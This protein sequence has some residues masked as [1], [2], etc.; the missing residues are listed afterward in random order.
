MLKRR[1]I[2]QAIAAAT[3]GSILPFPSFAAAG[4]LIEAS[5][6]KSDL[7]LLQSIY[8]TL[9]PG[10]YRY[11]TKA[12]IKARFAALSNRFVAPTP[13]SQVY[14]GF[15][16]LLASVRCG[17]SYANFYSQSE[18]VQ[19]ALFAG[20]NRLPFKF[21]WLDRTMVISDPAGVAGLMRGARVTHINGVATR[22]IL[23]T[24]L[25]YVR[26][27]GHNIGK[28]TSLLSVN[29]DEGYQSFDIFYALHYGEASAFSLQGLSPQ[30]RRFELSVQAIDLDARRAMTAGPALAEDASLWRLQIRPE[31]IAIISLPTF[32]IYSTKWDWKEWLAASFAQINAA[33]CTGL[34]L[35]I[36]GN[37]GGNDDCGPEILG[38]LTKAPLPAQAG[39]RRL[40]Y[41]TIPANLNPLLDTW[42]DQ[43]RDWG[44]KAALRS[45]GLYDLL[46]EAGRSGGGVTPKASYFGGKVVVLTD[47]SNSSATLQFCQMLRANRL[48]VLVGGTTGGNLRGINAEKFV[49][50]KLPGTGLEVDVPLVGFYPDG[51]PPDSGLVPDQI[52]GLTWRDIAG[53]TDPIMEAAL[54]RLA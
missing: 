22:T 32:G 50:A 30:G 42:N 43:F 21:I 28:Q 19:T 38:Y 53:A 34:V 14:L 25:P 13:L 11:N 16:K 35:D 31:K 6:I 33:G 1:D 27:D 54:K 4:N 41:R 45:D 44:D 29:R 40:A 15:S 3:I 47:A 48:G 51:T 20:K 36:R 23:S 7:A 5:A 46:D 39:S 9:H 8:E 2:L 10:L 52:V 18:A 24:L 37:E 49:F 26:A 17:H 12:E